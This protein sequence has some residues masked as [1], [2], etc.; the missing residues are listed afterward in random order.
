MINCVNDDMAFWINDCHI[1]F[2]MQ[3]TRTHR[4]CTCVGW[5]DK[6]HRRKR[7]WH[8]G[9]NRCYYDEMLRDSDGIR[10]KWKWDCAW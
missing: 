8:R 3:E 2:L 9:L 5:A 1:W 6:K 10:S 4:D 7:N